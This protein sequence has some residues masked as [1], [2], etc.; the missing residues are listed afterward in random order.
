[1]GKKISYT[2]NFL[3]FYG[4][5][6]PLS[7]L[8]L[9]V[10]YFF[11]DFLYLV[12][13]FIFPYRI[14]VIQKNISLSF[15]EKSK[16]EHLKIQYQFYKHFT[17]LLAESIKNISISKTE[18]KKRFKFNNLDVMN[19]LYDKN[20]NVILV[21]GHYN[22]WEW[23]ITSQALA[24]KHHSIGIGMPLK[25]GFWDKTL[26][27]RRG[28]FGMKI[29]S[30]ANINYLFENEPTPYATL[31]LSD[32]SPG[33]ERKSYWMQFLNQTTP[34]IFGC[35]YLAHHYNQSV[36]YFEII[37]VKRG[38]YEVNFKLICENPKDFKWGDITKSHTQLLEKTI[39]N[40][41][42]YWL[43]SHNRWKKSIPKDLDNLKE[44]QRNKF[45]EKFN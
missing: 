3:L 10:I 4:I 7:L 29:G 24:L 14:K 8:P 25:N 45:E 22:N 30:S 13:R 33:D 11:T 28:R 42:E 35:E 16:N 20:K 15:P 40:A 12:L 6:F 41:P 34:V 1:M 31:L 38:Y 21:S 39:L 17:D 9:R 5:I 26:N 19:A 44:K 36:V 43:W 32:Q 18:L 27:T 37:K 2:L 23:M